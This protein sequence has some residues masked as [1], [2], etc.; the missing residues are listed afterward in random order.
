MGLDFALGF[1][2]LCCAGGFGGFADE[3]AAGGDT[4]L[5]NLA[6]VYVILRCLPSSVI[7]HFDYAIDGVNVVKVRSRLH[8]RGATDIDN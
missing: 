4:I 6:S 5:V 1:F 7:T 2:Y 8:C 3:F